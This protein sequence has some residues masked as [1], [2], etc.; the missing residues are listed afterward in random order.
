[1]DLNNLNT[2]NNETSII[3]LLYS[4]LMSPLLMFFEPYSGLVKA[5]GILVALDILTGMMAAKKESKDLTSKSLWAKLPRVGLFLIALAAAKISSPL[6]MEFGIEAHQAGKWFCALYGLYELFSIL[7]NLGR[8]GLPVARQ[9]LELLKKKL[10][11]DIKQ[12]TEDKMEDK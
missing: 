10:P 2:N 3:K 1:M 5:I 9:F 6:L 11:D 12:I 7:E 4:L 8:L